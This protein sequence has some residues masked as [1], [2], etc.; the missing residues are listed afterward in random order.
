MNTVYQ[1]FIKLLN[2]LAW[3]GLFAYMVNRTAAYAMERLKVYGKKGD[4][5]PSVKEMWD[6]AIATNESDDN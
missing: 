6:D 5:F 3:V 2:N 1:D 4:Y